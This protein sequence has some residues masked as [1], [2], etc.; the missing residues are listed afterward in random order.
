LNQ[1]QDK[2]FKQYGIVGGI[3]KSGMKTD[4]QLKVQ[5][6]SVQTY[7]NRMDKIPF[8]PKVIIVDEAHH[9]AAETYVKILKY[10]KEVKIIGL[11]AT[12]YRASGEGLKHVFQRMI[13]TTTVKH[14]EEIGF[15]V[16]AR[17]FSYPLDNKKLDMIDIVKGD[18]DEKQVAKLM[19]EEQVIEDMVASYKTQAM[20]LKTICF[21]VNV[22]HS[23]KIVARFN[24]EGIPSA[25]MDA[26]TDNRSALIKRF[27]KGD[28]QI[29]CNVG[30]A[31]EGT[32]I[33][34][35]KCVMI[36]RATKSL[37]LYLQICGRGSRLF[38]DKKEFLLLDFANCFI[39]HGAPNKDQD[40]EKHFKGKKKG[41]KKEKPKEKQFKI[42][43]ETGEEYEGTR[44]DIPK[45]AKGVILEEINE[46]LLVKRRRWRLFE[47]E[48][49][50]I[51]N[52]KKATGE[53]WSLFASVYSWA[54]KLQKMKEP[55]PNLEELQDV[56]KVLKAGQSWVRNV[57]NTVNNIVPQ[58]Q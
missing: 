39:D 56:A 52:R 27:E 21:A 55:P 54:N 31:T 40:W 7:V 41:T 23:K 48:L 2:L 36:A 45:N 6:A 14:L 34:C 37:S 24:A 5:I 25:H 29:L 26:N 35:I 49:E 50:G 57:Y 20:G 10:Y 58:P 1:A 43:L 11:T 18:Y 17:C 32:D 13:L 16:P 51:K 28:I 8:V 42:K 53:N 33:P 46:D 9:S 44:Y 15:L 3:I 30:I 47:Q 4:F 12:P 19:M 38:P 22:E